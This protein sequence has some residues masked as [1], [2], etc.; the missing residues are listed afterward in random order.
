MKP[1]T[2][3]N[4]EEIAILKDWINAGALG[5][6]GETQTSSAGSTAVP[7]RAAAAASCDAVC[8]RRGSRSAAR[9]R[10]NSKAAPAMLRQRDGQ[11]RRYVE[12][13]TE[14]KSTGSSG[15]PEQM[16]A[17]AS[18]IDIYQEAISVPQ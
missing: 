17:K 5:T 18:I 11:V 2:P 14:V 15:A 10:P 16:S 7:A 13:R 4:P 6:S 8:A 9:K 1:V 12:R 3:L